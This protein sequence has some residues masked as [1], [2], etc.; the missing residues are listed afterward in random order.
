MNRRFVLILL[1]SLFALIGDRSAS[2][3]SRLVATQRIENDLIAATSPLAYAA[4]SSD[5]QKVQVRGALLSTHFSSFEDFQ[6]RIRVEYINSDSHSHRNSFVCVTHWSHGKQICSI[7]KRGVSEKDFEN[8]KF[9]GLWERISLAFQSPYV[10]F[11][12]KDMQRVSILARWRPELYEAGDFAFYNLALEMVGH[13]EEKTKKSLPKADLG[14]KGYI[15]TFNHITAQA[16]MTAIFGESLA[17]FMSDAHE[18]RNLPELATGNFA[19]SQIDDVYNGVVDNLVDMLNNEWGQELGKQLAAK[20]QIEHAT[21]WTPALLSNFLND[22][23]RYFSWAFQ[24]PFQPFRPGD[25]I[26]QRFSQKLNFVM[27]DQYVL[28]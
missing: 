2:E 5:K 21:I 16:L 4:D 19:Q 14:E 6:K 28:K 13:I 25:E 8:A 3:E 18:R 20:Y 10:V 17:N 11:H 1:L 23:Q 12:Y 24:L 15:N 22:I 27:A 9:G 26:V 7:L